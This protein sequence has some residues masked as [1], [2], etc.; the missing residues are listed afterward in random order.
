MN[1]GH[2]VRRPVMGVSPMRVTIPL[3]PHG[4]S[5]PPTLGGNASHAT[6]QGV[7]QDAG[8]W[9]VGGDGSAAEAALPHQNVTVGVPLDPRGAPPISVAVPHAISGVLMR[10]P[11]HAL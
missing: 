6:P 3:D 7:G 8:R 1:P 11:L 4:G 5:T 2:I 9:G 10:H